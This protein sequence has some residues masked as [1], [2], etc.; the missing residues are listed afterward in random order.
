M[1]FV[2]SLGTLPGTGM[3]RQRL[4]EVSWAQTTVLLANHGFERKKHC[5]DIHPL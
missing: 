3:S 4:H 1:L 2:G 5:N